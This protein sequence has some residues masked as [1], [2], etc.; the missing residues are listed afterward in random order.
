MPNICTYNWAWLRWSKH[1]KVVLPLGGKR[2]NINNRNTVDSGDFD[3]RG[4]NSGVNEFS[5]HNGIIG[6]RKVWQGL[7]WMTLSGTAGSLFPPTPIMSLLPFDEQ[8]NPS[9]SFLKE[10]LPLHTSGNS[11]SSFMSGSSNSLYN[12]G[13][14]SFNKPYNPSSNNTLCGP[15]TSCSSIIPTPWANTQGQMQHTPVRSS[16]G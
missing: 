13:N 9:S 11:N 8:L 1:H 3:R 2:M 14:V 6:L 15:S 16:H 12:F 4:H 5:R 10:H 7:L